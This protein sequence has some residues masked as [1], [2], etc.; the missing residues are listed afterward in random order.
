MFVHLSD[1]HTNKFNFIYCNQNCLV[2]AKTTSNRMHIAEGFLPPAWA[3][4]WFVVAIPVVAYGAYRTAKFARDSPQRMAMLAM[5]GAFIFVFS[6]LKLPSVTGSTS[7][8]T[9][10]GIAVVLF[11]PAVTAVLSTVVLIYQALLLAH[12][13]ITTLGANVVSMGVVGP[14]LGWL[15]YRLTRRHVGIPSATFVATAI[16]NWGTYLM[17][18]AQLGAAFPAGGGIGGVLVASGN[19]AAVF[20][21]TQLPI[22]IAEGLIAAAMVKHLIAVKPAVKARLGVEA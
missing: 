13:G 14:V 19:F 22:G 18:A 15:G 16:A 10:T 20:A 12:G 4:V 8:P 5:A 21:I 9:G 17:T 1:G 3:A 2:A 7:H 11:G 6:A